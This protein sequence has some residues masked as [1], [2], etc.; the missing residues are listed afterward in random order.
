ME[1]DL[2]V[3]KLCESDFVEGVDIFP[4]LRTEGNA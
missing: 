1:K 2:K 3:K 4:V